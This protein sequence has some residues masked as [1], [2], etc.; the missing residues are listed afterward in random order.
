[1]DDPYWYDL[2]VA[3]DPRYGLALQEVV[4]AA[5]PVP[6]G[7]LVA[8]LGAGTGALAARFAGAF[9]E[10][11]LHLIDRN[12]PKLRLAQSRLGPNAVVHQQTIDPA[13]PARLGCGGY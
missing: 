8:D 4:M 3:S 13:T 9:P 6:A 10:A 11:A 2:H 7:G 1:A 5:P 12:G